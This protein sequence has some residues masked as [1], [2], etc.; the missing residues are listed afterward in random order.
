MARRDP[1]GPIS[2]FVED[3]TRVRQREGFSSPDAAFVESLPF[4][5]LSGKNAALWRVR[6]LHYLVVRAALAVLPGIH[7]VLDLGAG[8]GWMARRLASRYRVAALDVDAGPGGLRAL[9]DR[10]VG[11]VRGE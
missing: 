2:R 9:G 3:Y 10:R 5:D 7:R 6:A 11:R 1:P 8:N 4:R